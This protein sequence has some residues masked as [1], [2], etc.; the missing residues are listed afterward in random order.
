MELLLVLLSVGAA[1]IPMVGLLVVMV[2][3]DRYDREPWWLVGLTFAWGAIGAILFAVIG[4]TVALVPIEIVV[5]EGAADVAG[6]VLIAPLIE[7]PAKA[8]V[9]PFVALTRHFDNATDGFVYGAAAG[10]GFGMTENFVYFA[11]AAFEGDAF[12]WFILVVVRT[13]FTALMHA[14][15]TSIVGAAIGATRYRSWAL[16]LTFVPLALMA[17]MGVHMLWNGPLAAAGVLD[18]DGTV[19]LVSYVVFP[20]EFVA[21]FGIYQ[22]CL[23]GESRL[24]RREL[25]TE[26]EAGT[27]PSAHVAKMGSWWARIRPGGWLPEGI[28][29]KAYLRA[30]TLLAFRRHQLSLSPE[31]DRVRREADE[32]R[33]QIRQLLRGA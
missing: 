32:L 26:A 13:L 29:R 7:E 18:G 11:G 24:I 20:L 31:H 19:A 9:L 17:A 16:R 3:L 1:G 14:C 30:A 12:S 28:D 23:W 25:A 4:S 8:L 33:Q 2:L 21:L 10:L 27:L 6:I 15:A 22:A 5:S